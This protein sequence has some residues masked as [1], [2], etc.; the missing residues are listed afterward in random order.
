M[1]RGR[2]ALNIK[3]DGMPRCLFRMQLGGGPKGIKGRITRIGDGVKVLPSAGLMALMC[4]DIHVRGGKYILTIPRVLALDT[5]VK[6]FSL[7]VEV[8]IT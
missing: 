1:G 2:G 3:E 5:F 8:P 6:H 7:F 4:Y